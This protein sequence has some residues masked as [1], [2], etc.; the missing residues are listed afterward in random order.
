GV[1]H[2]EMTQRFG[3]DVAYLVDG[4]TKLKRL[5]FSSKQEKQAENL[6]KLF[7]AMSND[8]RVII[9]KLADR[10]HNIRTLDPFPEER[11]REIAAET[12]YIF[13]PIA[14]RLGIWRIKW[15]LED[16]S[17]KFLEP[18]AYRQIHAWI[19]RTRAERSD[20]VQ[21]A[22]EAIQASLAKRGIEAEVTGRPKH[23]YSI[24]QKMLKQGLRF[25]DINDLTAIRIIC[26]R[27]EDCY[28]ALG[29]VNA[30]WL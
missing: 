29:V 13:A 12:L 27:D 16:R 2:E 8:V 9:V 28:P 7:L 11:R 1:S 24:Y 23:F 4:V 15:E 10:L 5:D 26:K 6:R 19:Q 22:I 21:N 25:E 14:H 20:I 3:V 18:E 30:L 17:F